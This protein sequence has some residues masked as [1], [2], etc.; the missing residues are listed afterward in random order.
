MPGV[1]VHSGESEAMGW[2]TV[3]INCI[4]S[5]TVDHSL[6]HL[7]RDECE[8]CKHAESFSGS[9]LGMF[10]KNQPAVEMYPCPTPTFAL[11]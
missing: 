11:G 6:L 7:C 2:G 9:Y 8:C 4:L 3:M 5:C 10:F 1:Y